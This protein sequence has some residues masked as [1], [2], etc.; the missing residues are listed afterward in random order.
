MLKATPL[1]SIRKTTYPRDRGSS[2]SNGKQTAY[3]QYPDTPNSGKDAMINANDHPPHMMYA[4]C[5]NIKA[6]HLDFNIV[7][8]HVTTY[9]T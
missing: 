1:I 4:A 9:F 7:L 2:V 5:Y 3:F 8:I 6:N